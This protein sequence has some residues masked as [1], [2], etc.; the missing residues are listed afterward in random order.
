M[1]GSN[2]AAYLTTVMKKPTEYILYGV[3]IGATY[4]EETVV[5]ENRYSA[6]DLEEALQAQQKEGSSALQETVAFIDRLAHRAHFNL[7]EQ[8]ISKE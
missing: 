3:P 2:K 4:E 5:F 8:N 7:P 6:N 1:D